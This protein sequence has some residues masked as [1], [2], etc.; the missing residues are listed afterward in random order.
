[1]QAAVARPP[2]LAHA[3]LAQ[4]VEDFVV[5]QNFSSH[6]LAELSH[7]AGFGGAKPLRISEGCSKV[8]TTGDGRSAAYSDVI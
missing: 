7:F 8:F 6:F 5:S 3:A 1:L 4:L 2:H